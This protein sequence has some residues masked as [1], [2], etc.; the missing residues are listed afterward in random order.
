MQLDVFYMQ[1]V[2]KEYSSH[3]K[4]ALSFTCGFEEDCISLNIP[5]RAWSMMDGKSLLAMT[6]K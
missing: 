1:V 6:L 5:R 3:A 4:P 2:E